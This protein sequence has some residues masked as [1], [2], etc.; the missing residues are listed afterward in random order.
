MYIVLLGLCSGPLPGAPDWGWAR[1]PDMGGPSSGD[2]RVTPTVPFLIVFFLLR[3]LS[4][5]F[6]VVVV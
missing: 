6:V 3:D 2:P 4:G 1:G 5:V